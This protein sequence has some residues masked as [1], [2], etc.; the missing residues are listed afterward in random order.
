MVR[1]I[2]VVLAD[3]HLLVRK[4]FRALLSQEPDIEVVGE[5][6]DGRE[7]MRLVDGL[8]PDVLVMDLEMPGMSGLEAVRLLGKRRYPVRVLVLTMHKDAERIL[9]VLRAGVCSYILK[10]GAVSDLAAGI[11][12]VSQGEVFLSREVSTQVTG[13]VLDR[14]VT[15]GASSLL[16]TLSGR[17]R[18]ILQ[19]IAEGNTRR[20]IATLLCIS[21]KTV[22]THRANLMRKL[23]VKDDAALVRLAIRHGLVS[24]NG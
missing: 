5:A 19:L 11:R 14:L 21:P 17:E 15:E 13:G 2:R 23:R 8:H 7:A 1:R 20:E 22:D 4:G 3:D 9:Q 12:A 16:E 10:D 18:E 24:P 6:G